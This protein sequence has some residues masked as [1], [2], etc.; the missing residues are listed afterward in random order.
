[1]RTNSI[2]FTTRLTGL[3]L[4]GLSLAA[5]D[6]KILLGEFGDT[7]GTGG[8]IVTAGPPALTDGPGMT[9]DTTGG[10]SDTDGPPNTSATAGSGN[11]IDTDGPPAT[12]DTDPGTTGDPGDDA[13]D[14]WQQDCPTGQKCAPYTTFTGPTFDAFH[15]IDLAPDPQPTGSPCQVT[16]FPNSGEDDCELGAVCMDADP[17]TGTG[18]CVALC[19]GSPVS[20]VC[21]AGTHCV[22]FNDGV[23]NLCLADCDPLLQDCPAGEECIHNPAQPDNFICVLDASSA[24][25]QA[26]DPCDF[27]NACDPGLHCSPGQTAVECTPGEYGCCTPYCDLSAP[28]TCPGVGQECLPLYPSNPAI[29]PALADIGFCGLP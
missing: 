17:V 19:Q 24:E 11:P 6:P 13:C 1:M 23:L 29:P 28:N 3:L 15:C 4:T 9:S 27:L 14:P 16:G 2:S 26:H 18:T 20:P 22:V 25:G 10:P 8:P 7:E 12:S 5:C 21:D